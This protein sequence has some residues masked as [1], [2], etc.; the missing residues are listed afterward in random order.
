MDNTLARPESWVVHPNERS[1]FA[2]APESGV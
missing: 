2:L 1:T